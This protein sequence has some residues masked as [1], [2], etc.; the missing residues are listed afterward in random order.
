MLARCE[1]PNNKSYP[2]YG[3]RGV[4]VCAEWHDV[5]TFIAWLEANGYEK[6]LELDR[7]DNNGEY[8]PDNCRVVTPQQNSRNR[9]DNKRY[10]VHGEMLMPIE[11]QE[12]YGVKEATFR[13]RV[14]QYGQ[15]PEEALINKRKLR[16]S[17]S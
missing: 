10:L 4:S 14:D 7:K 17:G 16:G 6:G 8:S 2:R 3:G 13:A 12:K 1:N 11:V 5:K 15:S 9:R